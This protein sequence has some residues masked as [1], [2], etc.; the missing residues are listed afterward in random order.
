MA[1]TK[2]D[3]LLQVGQLMSNVFFN[4]SQSDRF[5]E[6]ER[7]MM[8]GLQTQWDELSHR[9]RAARALGSVKSERKATA[10]R[11]NGKKGGRPRKGGE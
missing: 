5:T 6:D 10:A 7:K 3:E 9:T 2:P 8:K 1:Q 11:Q 4:W